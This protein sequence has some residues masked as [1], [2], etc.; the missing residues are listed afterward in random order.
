MARSSM[1]QATHG[2]NGSRRGKGAWW[3][4]GRAARVG[5]NAMAPWDSKP[6]AAQ[7]HWASG[8]RPGEPASGA[9]SLGEWGTARR[10]GERTQ[11][12]PR[13]HGGGRRRGTSCAEG[14]LAAARPRRR[15][16]RLAAGWDRTGHG[17]EARPRGRGLLR[18]K[19]EWRMG[20][21]V[22]SQFSSQVLRR[23]GEWLA[24]RTGLATLCGPAGEAVTDAQGRQGRTDRPYRLRAALMRCTASAGRP[25]FEARFCR[26]S[27]C[28]AMSAYVR[29]EYVLD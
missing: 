27:G 29:E 1:G 17:P 12:H 24:R 4:D 8:A 14:M 13:R 9:A 16:R 23:K 7:H 10:A 5:W 6:M 2:R 19:G 28:C 21:G 26:A 22:R 3:G 11:G 18:R 20:F 25:Q 15:G